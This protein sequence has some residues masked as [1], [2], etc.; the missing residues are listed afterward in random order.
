MNSP[1][2]VVVLYCSQEKDL[3]HRVIKPLTKISKDIVVVSL[4]HYFTGEEDSD[5]VKTL[6]ELKESYSIVPVVL[7]WKYIPGAPQNFWPKE[8]RLQGLG[9][10][11]AN[12]KYVLF[13]DAD[14]I[15]NNP[16]AFLAWYETLDCTSEQSYKL[17]NYWYFLSERR[18]SK[19][20]E[21][22]IILVP[23][24]TL[25]LN[26]FRMQ[27]QGE[28]ELLVKN[29]ARQVRSLQGEVMFDHFSW[30]RPKEVLL[31][32]VTTWGHRNDKDWVTLVRKACSEDPL[33]THDFVHGY[34]YDIL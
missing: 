22:S 33:T 12:A 20:I 31:Q 32:K 14:E 4:S 28:R 11:Q 1:L 25:H 17:A 6:Q 13:V 9:A 23:R 34:E 15:L 7:P 26:M 18:R 21:D 19:A 29:P 3:I 5:A 30:V 27:G 10:T 8:M 2:S 24:F 16:P